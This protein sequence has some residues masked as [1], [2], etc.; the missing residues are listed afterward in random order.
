LNAEEKKKRKNW[1][2]EWEM[3]ALPILEGHPDVGL[4]TIGSEMGGKSRNHTADPYSELSSHHTQ[5]AFATVQ[6]WISDE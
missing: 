6:Y 4:R 2:G 3:G 1:M 5:L